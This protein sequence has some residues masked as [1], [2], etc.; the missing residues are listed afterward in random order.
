MQYDLEALEF[1]NV[2][3]ILKR[4]AKTSY[5]KELIDALVPTN[6]FDEV[7]KR[8]QETKEAFMAVVKLSDIPLGGLY[9]VKGS[10]ERAQIGGIL[11]PQELLN[12]VGLLDCASNV[13]RYFKSLESAK[14]EIPTLK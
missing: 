8:N 1:Y 10:L 6:D 11:E 4:Y 7:I 5:A 13:L 3:T 2:L 14:I 9:Q 12:V